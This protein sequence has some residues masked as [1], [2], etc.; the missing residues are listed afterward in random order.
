MIDDIFKKVA[1]KGGQ[2][3]LAKEVTEQV[4]KNK[5]GPKVPDGWFEVD[6]ITRRFEKYTNVEKPRADNTIP[7]KA[8]HEAYK[9][10]AQKYY[11]QKGKLGGYPRYVDPDTGIP[12]HRIKSNSTFN[13]DGDLIVKPVLLSEDQARRARRETWEAEQTQG[14]SATR[15]LV[16]H[17]AEL[18]FVGALANGL[19]KSE[20]RAFYKY[21]N[22]SDRWP[23][24]IVGNEGANLLGKK[25]DLDFHQ[26]HVDVHEL[27]KMAG[28]NPH[29]INFK[30]ATLEER[31]AFLDEAAPILDQID[32]FIYNQ[33]MA[34]KY[35]KQFKRYTELR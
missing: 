7:N 22:A 34:G 12:T 27:L 15:E 1:L 2:K 30:G 23:N 10:G 20:R 11:K 35:P 26:I 3:S 24:L 25:G 31:F 13:K 9:K 18:S 8:D 5:I 17:R 29:K 16:H 19:S 21:I 33:T 32:E 4:A 28:L 6:K 14:P